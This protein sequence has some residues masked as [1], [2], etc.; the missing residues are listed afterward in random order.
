MDEEQKQMI[1][2]NIEYCI[3]ELKKERKK[4]MSK[5]VSKIIDIYND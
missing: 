3:D 2:M 1:L 4:L 5:G